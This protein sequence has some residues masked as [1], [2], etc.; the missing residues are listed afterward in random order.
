MFRIVVFFLFTFASFIPPKAS[1]KTAQLKFPRVKAAFQDK[2]KLM[3][4][5]YKSKQLNIKNAHLFIRVFKQEDELELW[6][7][8][9]TAQQFTKIKIFK[10]CAKSGTI[11]PK[12][13]AGDGQVPEGLYQINRFNPASNYHLSLGIDYPNKTDKLRAGF[14]PTGGDIFIH[15]ECVTIGCMPLTNEFIE[16]LYVACVEA[17][18]ALQKTIK[19]EIYPCRLTTENSQKIFK[20]Y[21]K[22]TDWIKVWKVLQKSF[23]HF[24][25]KKYPVNYAF[26][27]KGNYLLKD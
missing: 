14:F 8:S 25:N 5:L 11:G 3:T 18:E 24:E 13:R 2:G 20:K 9:K 10:I 1:F 6:A 15:G 4:D 26:D 27:A 7:K 16:E 21:A 19:V 17:K 23:D 12:A 22:N